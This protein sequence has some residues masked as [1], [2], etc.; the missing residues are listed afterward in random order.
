[1]AK[2]PSA[3]GA[4]PK[5]V[6]K[7]MSALARGGGAPKGIWSLTVAGRASGEPR[8][9]AISPV[10][11]DGVR[12]LVAP[13]GVVDWVRNLRAAGVGELRRGRQ[14][15]PVSASELSAEQAGP[16]LK[17]YVTSVP[18]TRPYLDVSYDRPAEEFVAIAAKHPVFELRER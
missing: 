15:V 7:L 3:G 13:Y 12:Y 8:T 17:H 4:A 9:V 1:M 10:T 5:F 16:V 6:S 18:I 11:I 2:Q 14:R